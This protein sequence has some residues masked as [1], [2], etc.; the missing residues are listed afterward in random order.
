MCNSNI[1][2]EL[3]KDSC[4]LDETKHVICHWLSAHRSMDPEVLSS[5]SQCRTSLQEDVAVSWSPN[6]GLG[7]ERARDS[8]TERYKQGQRETEKKRGGEEKEERG[9]GEGEGE[10]P[11]S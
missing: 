11:M 3:C 6:C 1:C 9:A 2:L 10:M 4:C 5:G 7:G 8:E